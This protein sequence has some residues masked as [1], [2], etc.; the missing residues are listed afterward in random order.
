MEVHVYVGFLGRKNVT[1][2]TSG[3]ENIT[4][5]YTAKEILLLRQVWRFMLPGKGMSCFPIFVRAK[6]NSLK[7]GVELKFEAH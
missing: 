4:F 6:Y 5:G 2:L 7:L 3:A 1:L